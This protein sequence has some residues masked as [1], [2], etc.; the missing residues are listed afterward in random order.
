[1]AELR[2]I[3]AI[4]VHVAEEVYVGGLDVTSVIDG[5]RLTLTWLRHH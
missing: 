1:M 2:N 4:A 5:I 3:A